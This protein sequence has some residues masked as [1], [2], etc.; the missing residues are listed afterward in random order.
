MERTEGLVG[1]GG[2]NISLNVLFCIDLFGIMLMF[3]IHWRE[4][5][6]ERGEK[7]KE[8]INKIQ[9]DEGKHYKLI[10]TETNEAN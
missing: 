8:I 1:G 4:R 9:K 2:G 5:K 7:G 6:E 10:L 3:Y